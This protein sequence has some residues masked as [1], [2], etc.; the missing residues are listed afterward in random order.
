MLSLGHLYGQQKIPTQPDSAKQKAINAN[1][2]KILAYEWE[3]LKD[4]VRKEELLDS[5]K[6]LKST[7]KIKRQQL[8][9][10]LKEMQFK[11]SL[12]RSRKKKEIDS[13]RLTTNGFA[14]IGLFGDTLFSIYSGRGSYSAA[15]RADI[16]TSRVNKLGHSLLFNAD[17]IKLEQDENAVVVVHAGNTLVTVT[18]NDALWNSTTPAELA[19]HY[20][21][22]ITA[23]IKHYKKETSFRTLAKEIGVALIIILLLLFIV[24]LLNR[25]NKWVNV[26]IA[27]QENKALKGIHFKNYTLFESKKQVQLIQQFVTVLKWVLIVIITY[28]TIPIL[29]SIFPWTQDMAGSLT[30]YIIRPLKSIGVA[31]WNYLPNLITIAILTILFTYI[32]KLFKFLRSEIDTGKLNISGFHNEWATPTYQII[33]ILLLA[34]WFI[35]IFPFLPG[36]D[37]P[38]FKGVSVFLGFLLTFGSAGP[39][40]NI[41]AGIVLTYMRQFTL[42]DRVKIGEVTGD[43]IEKSMLVTRIKTIKNEIISIP[44][45]TVMSSHTINYSSESKGTGLILNTTV[46]IGYDTP[47]RDMYAALIK[48]ALKTE[49]ILAE[50]KPFVLQTS[51]DDFFVSYQLNAY[52]HE[53]N[54][55]ADIY[56]FLHQNIQDCCNEA[57]IE[58]MSPH[59]RSERDGNHTT[60]PKQYLDKDYQAPGFMFVSNDEKENAG[61]K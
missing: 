55:Q 29:F 2:R 20:R 15:E 43:V 21:K 3:R 33:R 11:D 60:I 54:L 18:E 50:P 22:L 28:F 61:K 34:F 27:L 35:L 46:T 23:D 53:A 16:I 47:W 26:K 57:G 45:T 38:V 36:S 12:R 19:E 32:I 30:G 7:E 56:S 9:Q 17:S 4:S 5:I 14:V 24:F 59:Y 1:D 40:S 10:Q 39:L 44:N 6:S 48:A 13:L 51:L 58:I 49:H 52:T 31:I 8:E 37:S 41:I 25:L 42:G